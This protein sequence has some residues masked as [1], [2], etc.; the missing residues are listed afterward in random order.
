MSIDLARYRELF[1]HR[2][3][4]FAEQQPS[5]AYFPVRES[6]A[7]D[8]I[9]EHLDGLASYGV[10][11]IRPSDQTVKYVL[12]D[13]DTHGEQALEMLKG[14]VGELVWPAP[15]PRS[16]L[17]ERSGSKG[18]HVWLFLS[19]PLPARQVRAWL[20]ARF[21]W[22]TDY[23]PLEVFP[24]Q[25][26]VSE[27]GYGNL[28]KLPLGRHA[29][30][31]NL[32]EFVPVQG[33]AS[34]IDDV[35]PLESRLIPA[36]PAASP[37]PGRGS[38]RGEGRT[39][40]VPSSPFPC[41]DHILRAGVGEGYR[42]RAM[43]HLALYFYGHGLDQDLA[44]EACIRANENFDPQL[45]ER[46]VRQ[47]VAS[48][49]RGRFASARCGSDWLVEI[50]PGPCREG[51]SVRQAQGGTLSRAEPGTTI[52]VDVVRVTDSDRKRVTIGHPDA[53]NQPTLVVKR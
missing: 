22:G 39:V 30:S 10:Y 21:R 16:L 26:T 11:V 31:G 36:A 53:D 35:V 3:D 38:P 17:L 2:D 9:Q 25:D 1:V 51:W 20:A 33:W 50:C 29:V 28:V 37:L 40:G 41:I 27:G 34:G 32:S 52:E 15:G 49:Y 13:L 7:D 45:T 47:K 43:F 24:K 19:D 44:E 6:I 23:P 8:D 5:G 14:A 48:A 12:F 18:W 42:D 4:V 46:E